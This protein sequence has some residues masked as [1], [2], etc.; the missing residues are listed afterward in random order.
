MPLWRLG[1]GGPGQGPV[2]QDLVHLHHGLVRLHD[3]LRGVHD[4]VDHAAAGGGEQGIEDEVRQHLQ[5]VPSGGEQ[6][7]RRDQQGEGPVDAGEESGL[8]GPAAHGILAGQ[9]AVGLD[10]VVE[11]LKGVNGLL[12]H[13]HHRDAPDILHCLSAHLLDLPLVAV[14]EPGVPAAHHGHHAAQGQHHGEKAQQAHPPVKDEQQHDGGQRCHHRRRQVR[15]LVGQQVLRQ[16]GVVVDDL[17]QLAGAVP[18]EE[19]QGQLHQVGHPGMAH[20]PGGPEGGD[21]GAHQR[22]EVQGDVGHGEPHRHPAP[23]GQALRL[24]D[25]REDCQRLP[26]YQPHAHIGD[27]PQHGGGAGQH[28]AQHRQLP[29]AA[30]VGQ[31]PGQIRSLFQKD[32]SLQIVSANS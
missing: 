8:A 25:G 13:F 7:R 17:P 5:P 29:V 1:N 16:G 27:Q 19:A 9:V 24:C 15:Q 18:G 3:G 20:V 32:P 21:V 11:C 26:G 31:Q 28:T 14:E 4:P 12:E 30:G 22:R 2:L 23:A 10:G 6:Q